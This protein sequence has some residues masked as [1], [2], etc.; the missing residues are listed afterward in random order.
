M[1]YRKNA[2]ALAL[3]LIAG[4]AKGQKAARD[5]S[6]ASLEDLMNIEV[7]TVSK[8]EQKLSHAP[9]AVFVIT[10]EDIRRSGMT[11]IPDLL[12]MVPGLQVGQMQTGTWGVSARGFNTDSANKLLV[13]IDGR[14]VYTPL[15][16]GVFW[17]QQDYLLQD[18]DRIEVISGPGGTLW[19]AS[20]E[21]SRGVFRRALG[22]GP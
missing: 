3:L 14:S 16:S 19:G 18:I 9:A 15:F 22:P 10:Q 11:A 1:K 12:R 8:K 5:L 13:M 4:A 2:L 6:E 20:T 7:T 21:R 17:D